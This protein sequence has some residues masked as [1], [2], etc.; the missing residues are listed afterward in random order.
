MYRAVFWTNLQCNLRVFFLIA[1]ANEVKYGL[2]LVPVL[3]DF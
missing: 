1:V 2:G 3:K